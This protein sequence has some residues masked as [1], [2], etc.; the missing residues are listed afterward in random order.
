MLQTVGSIDTAIAKLIR[1]NLSA[2]VL[3][4]NLEGSPATGFIP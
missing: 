4:S 1:S 3:Q 2:Q